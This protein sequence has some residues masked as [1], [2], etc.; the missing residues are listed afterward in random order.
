MTNTALYLPPYKTEQSPQL[1]ARKVYSP[2]GNTSNQ[3]AAV[4]R[5]KIAL[6]RYAADTN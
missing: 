2:I 3:A 1:K 6:Q 5:C 4:F